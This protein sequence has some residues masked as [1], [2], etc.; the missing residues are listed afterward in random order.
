MSDYWVGLYSHS[1]ECFHIELLSETIDIGVRSLINE[2]KVDYI[3]CTHL[4]ETREGVERDLNNLTSL[5]AEFKK[6][7]GKKTEED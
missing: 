3:I 5:L 2:S 7:M 6:Q 1:Q 4:H